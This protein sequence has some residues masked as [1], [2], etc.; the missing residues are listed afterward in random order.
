MYDGEDFDKVVW[1]DSKGW[2]KGGSYM[3]LR[4]VQM[5]LETWDRTNLQEQETPLIA[6]GVR[7]LL[8]VKPTNFDEVDLSKTTSRFTYLKWRTKTKV[9]TN[10]RHGRRGDP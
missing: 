10:H 5:H 3:A 2:M 9:G 7:C 1:T 4:L 8:W 6:Q